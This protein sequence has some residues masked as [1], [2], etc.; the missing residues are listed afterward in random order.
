MIE[1]MLENPTNEYSSQIKLV[2]EIENP[3]LIAEL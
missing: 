1:K 2:E 3:I